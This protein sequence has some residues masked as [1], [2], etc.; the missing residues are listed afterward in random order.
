MWHFYPVSSP[1][2]L[3][4]SELCFNILQKD[5]V[6]RRIIKWRIKQSGPFHLICTG[7][8]DNGAK[9]FRF[10]LHLCGCYSKTAAMRPLGRFLFILKCYMGTSSCTPVFSSTELVLILLSGLIKGYLSVHSLWPWLRFLSFLS[11]FLPEELSTVLMSL[12]RLE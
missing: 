1:C 9:Q 2:K 4:E 3:K 8:I 7:I 6:R 5:R 11:S 10:P 12:F